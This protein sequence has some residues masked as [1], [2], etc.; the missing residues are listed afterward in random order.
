[1][2]KWEITV[3]LL[4][5]LHLALIQPAAAGLGNTSLC[6]PD[7]GTIWFGTHAPVQYHRS[8][9]DLSE[10]SIASFSR[11]AG[12]HPA[13]ITFSHEWG[14]NRS[15]PSEQF[16]IINRAGATPWVRLMLRS[17][18]RQYRPEPVFTLNRITS[19]FFDQEF[20]AWADRVRV[21]GYPVLIEYGTEVNGKWFSWNG[22]WN[23]KEK[24]A[25]QFREAYRHI[26]Q[27]MEEEQADNLVWVYH[28]NWHNNPSEPWNTC[29]A[30]YPGDQYVDILSLSL[31][32]ALTPGA[33]DGRSFSDMMNE[34]YPE[35]TALSP[36]KPVIIGEMGTDLRNL[37]TDPVS[38]TSDAYSSVING[39]W[40]GVAGVVWWNSAWQS[41]GDQRVNTTMRIEESPGMER[42]FRAFIGPDERYLDRTSLTCG[43]TLQQ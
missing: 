2:Q 30:Y 12:K 11:A 33:S 39:T 37:H 40:P 43:K 17:D 16:S 10:S 26:R 23:G 25:L 31:Y 6:L 19:G 28:V 13:I 18:I 3:L 9:M 35:I 29:A 34:S 21:L 8:E 15:F 4:F 14:I 32:G 36:G 27:V 1:V 20:R 5:F 42:V 38:W 22:Y 41:D 7:T 24:G